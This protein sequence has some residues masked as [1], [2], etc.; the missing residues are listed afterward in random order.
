MEG[1]MIKNFIAAA[2]LV[3]TGVLSGAANANDPIYTG[4]FNDRAVGGYDTVEYFKS[5]Q[6]TKGSKKFKLDFMG[7]EWDL[8]GCTIW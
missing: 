6:P 7:A 8:M 3:F 1:I 4:R 5:G 2:L